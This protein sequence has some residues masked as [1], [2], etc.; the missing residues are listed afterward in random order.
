MKGAYSMT[1]QEEIQSMRK[2]IYRQA[3]NGDREYKVVNSFEDTSAEDKYMIHSFFRPFQPVKEEGHRKTNVEAGFDYNVDSLL[4]YPTII[5]HKIGGLWPSYNRLISVHVPLC[6]FKCWHCYND[7]KLHSPK[8]AEWKTA[9]DI[10]K[11]F[12]EQRDFDLRR[13]V[14]SN[15]LR[16]TGGEPF[17]VPDLILECLQEL[18]VQLSKQ[19]VFLWTETDLWPFIA[20]NGDSYVEQFTFNKNNTTFN[21]LQELR[22]YKNLAVHP[23][24]HGLDDKIFSK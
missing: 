3:P 22:K 1:I 7:K 15:V 10:V 12:I 6:P 4:D 2:K 18:E 5:Q 20:D 21:V 16:I 17:L 8:N 24:F 19:R 9:H 23:C 14:E 13:G 11:A